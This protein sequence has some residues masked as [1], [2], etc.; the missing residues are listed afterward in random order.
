MKRRM[1]VTLITLAAAIGATTALAHGEAEPQHGGIVRSAHDLDFEL[2]ARDSGAALYLG[3]H[4]KPLPTAGMSGTLTVLDGAA[5]SDAPLKPGGE[6]MLIAD[7][8][9]LPAGA[10]VVA[11]VV[12]AAGRATTV[13]FNLK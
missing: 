7:G 4:G 8:I 9:R 13:R 2:V 12:D 1:L 11:V 6:N 5:K 3:D 10:R